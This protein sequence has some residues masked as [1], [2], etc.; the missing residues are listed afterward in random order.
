LD[1]TA[2][3][4]GFV[5]RLVNFNPR[6]GNRGP[7]SPKYD[8]H[9]A[10]QTNLIHGTRI[11]VWPALQPSLLGDAFPIP[12]DPAA[13]LRKREPL[14]RRRILNTLS[15]WPAIEWG[16]KPGFTVSPPAS[17]WFLFNAWR[18]TLSMVPLVVSSFI[19]NNNNDSRF[20]QTQLVAGN[21]GVLLYGLQISFM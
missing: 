15:Q 5:S 2:L 20:G 1:K 6:T 4:V 3:I 19:N 16:A 10:T 13:E 11:P 21:V 17:R 9:R 12:P 14:T 8:S 7:A 18:G